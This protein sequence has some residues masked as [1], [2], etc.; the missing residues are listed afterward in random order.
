MTQ[1]TRPCEE[2]VLAHVG[3]VQIP[4]KSKV[5]HMVH[6]LCF[7]VSPEVLAAI[8]LFFAVTFQLSLLGT[9][10]IILMHGFGGCLHNDMRKSCSGLGE[11]NMC[12]CARV[13]V[14]VCVSVKEKSRR[15]VRVGS[16]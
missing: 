7:Y 10:T 15:P 3:M 6:V 13:Q 14:R 9:C 2:C 12:V 11:N 8:S 1:I 5:L 4:N 16:W